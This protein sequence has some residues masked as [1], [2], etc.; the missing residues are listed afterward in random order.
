M[1]A[2]EASPARTRRTWSQ[3]AKD[4]IL[5]EAKILGAKVSGVPRAHDVSV[6]QIFRWRSEAQTRSAPSRTVAGRVPRVSRRS[7]SL[8]WRR[9]T[10]QS[11]WRRYGPSCVRSSWPES[12]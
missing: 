8:R 2:L 5:A 11:S 12:S 3:A 10:K 7:P 9:R 1:D 6:H 4:L